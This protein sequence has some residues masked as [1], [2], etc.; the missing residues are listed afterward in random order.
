MPAYQY[1]PKP[2][3][4]EWTKLSKTEHQHASGELVARTENGLWM[5]V[6]TNWCYGT[7]GIACYE[8]EQR[9]RVTEEHP[10]TTPEETA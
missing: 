5:D 6:T 9:H 2:T 3:A 1:T 4:G 8:V 10:A 7:K